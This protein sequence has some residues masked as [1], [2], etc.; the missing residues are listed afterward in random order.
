MRKQFRLGETR[1]AGYVFRVP[2]RERPLVDNKPERPCF[3]LTRCSDEDLAT[4]ALMTTK[5]TEALFG[6]TLL[7]L[8]GVSGTLPGQENA[9]VNLSS[10]FGLPTDR[11]STSAVNLARHLPAVR[12][13][14][15][16]ALGV[17]SGVGSGHGGSIRGHLVRLTES[18]ARRF[19]FEYGI[20]VTEH[21]YSAARRTQAVVRIVDGAAF[22]VESETAADFR[23]APEDVIPPREAAWVR[24]LPTSWTLP[25]IDTIRLTSVR[26]RWIDSARRETWLERQIEDVFPV[27]I[28]SGTLSRIEAVLAVR[29]SL[30]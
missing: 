4:L 12:M 6:A 22:L 11:L 29:L 18:M 26:E 3:L 13:A 14:L 19:E 1:P 7:E 28:D 16:A 15:K 8:A 17:G 27:A 10:I 2:A 25:V 5:R 23:S 21:A 20:V 9:Y 24:Q 30:P